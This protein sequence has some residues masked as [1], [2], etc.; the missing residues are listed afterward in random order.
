MPDTAEPTQELALD[1]NGTDADDTVRVLVDQHDGVV[2]VHGGF[3]SVELRP[4]GFFAVVCNDCEDLQD[5]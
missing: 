1:E 2:C 3:D 4:P 5:V